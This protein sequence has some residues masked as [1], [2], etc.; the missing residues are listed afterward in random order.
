MWQAISIAPFGNDL[1]LALIDGDG[2]HELVFRCRRTIGG[3]INAETK[4]RI[5]VHP[6][7]WRK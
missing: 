3:W 5:D 4:Q 6:T 2:P 1:E 7:H